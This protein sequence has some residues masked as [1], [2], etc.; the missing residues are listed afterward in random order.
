[1][2]PTDPIHDYDRLK[3]LARLRAQELRRE[4]IDDVWRVAY[5]AW[6]ASLAS[7]R[8]GAQRLARA[9]GRHARARPKRRKASTLQRSGG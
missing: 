4:A 5:A 7:A 3:E 1:M 6:A 2:N 8:R 9:L